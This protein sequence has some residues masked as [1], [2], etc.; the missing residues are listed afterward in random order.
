M[1]STKTAAYTVVITGVL[2]RRMILRLR[3]AAVLTSLSLILC[4]LFIDSAVS[5]SRLDVFCWVAIWLFTDHAT[6]GCSFHYGKVGHY[7]DITFQV[8]ML[9]QPSTI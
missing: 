6:V 4:P 2:Q 7:C 5:V 1:V 3:R 8:G 9:T